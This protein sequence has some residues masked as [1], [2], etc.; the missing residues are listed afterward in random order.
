MITSNE[1][2]EPAASDR[3]QNAAN[4]T[5]IGK[6]VFAA[7]VVVLAFFVPLRHLVQ[8]AFQTD[9]YSHIILI[10]FVSI[11][12]A[13]LIRND[14]PK[15]S[16]RSRAVAITAGLLAATILGSYWSFKRSGIELPDVDTLAFQTSAF[17]LTLISVFAFMLGR[18]KTRALAFPLAFLLLMVPFPTVVQN[19]IETFFQH[20]SAATAAFFFKVSGTTFF[21]QNTF[22]QLPGINL[23]VAPECSGIRSSLALF[24]TSL[25]AG[26]LFLRRTWKR[27][28]LTCL[29]IPLGIVRNGLRIFVIGELCVHVGPEMIDSPIHRR[30]G[31][32]FFALSLLP[33]LLV[34][35]SLAKSDRPNRSRQSTTA[36]GTAPSI[37]ESSSDPARV[38]SP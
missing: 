27:V 1:P 25:V 6:L 30:G 3:R 24:I 8:F 33:F 18:E 11:Y 15:T 14:L 16:E 31:P 34:L 4:R 32:V 29:V 35:Y 23:E 13:W 2:T 28:L 38:S 19:G 21:R 22:F 9:L 10:P 36:S 26:Q 12:L 17:V 5:L 7:G 37:S 20:T